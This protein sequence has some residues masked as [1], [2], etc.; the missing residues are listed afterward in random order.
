MFLPDFTYPQYHPTQ[1]QLWQIEQAASRLP[2][3]NSQAHRIQLTLLR[4]GYAFLD[5]R[6][7]C[8]H[9]RI[10]LQ[11]CAAALA[12]ARDQ[13]A[14]T[15]SSGSQRGGKRRRC[16]TASSR[17]DSEG[18]DEAT[19]ARAAAAPAAAVVAATAAVAPVAAA[20]AAADSLSA[21]EA[22]AQQAVD[23][24]ALLLKVATTRKLTGEQS[25]QYGI[26]VRAGIQN[27]TV[28]PGSKYHL[29]LI[30]SLVFD[31]LP[32]AGAPN[33]LSLVSYLGDYLDSYRSASPDQISIHG[34]VQSYVLWPYEVLPSTQQQLGE[35]AGVEEVL[36]RVEGRMEQLL[37]D[38]GS[39]EVAAVLADRCERLAA[40]VVIGTAASLNVDVLGVRQ[41]WV[42]KM[43]DHGLAALY[44]PG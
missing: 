23:D 41:Q 31:A 12:A 39:G 27:S 26:T 3:T 19:A 9:Q 35:V 2:L 37:Q 1:P 29:A 30:S 21:S 4:Q 15:S 10:L 40:P 18:E 16:S 20:H 11:E 8:C 44:K 13:V 32:M 25:R 38:M 33:A 7:F 22:A 43:L 14:A 17:A 24:V 6:Q 28:L 34:Y 5:I 42:V 36:R